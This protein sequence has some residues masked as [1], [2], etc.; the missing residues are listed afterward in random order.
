MLLVWYVV[1]ETA[2]VSCERKIDNPHT[3]GLESRHQTRQWAKRTLAYV[4]Y[5]Q[6]ILHPHDYC[7][8][9]HEY[10]TK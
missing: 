5:S 8:L 9:L 1:D 2:H 10:P 3:N 4:S 7:K 6:V